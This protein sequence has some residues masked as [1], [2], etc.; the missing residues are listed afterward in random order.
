MTIHRLLFAC[1]A[2]VVAATA[3]AQ[4]PFAA[5]GADAAAIQTQVDAFRTALGGLNANT[6]GSVG[7]GRREINW[8]SAN[9]ALAAPGFLPNDF[10]NFLSP[11]GVVFSLGTGGTGFQ[12]SADAVNATG[13]PAEFGGINAT[14]PTAFAPFS[15]ERI[16]TAL[17]TN[18][19]DVHFLIPGSSTPAASRGFGAV[20][21]DVDSA[22]SS[23]LEFFRGKESLGVFTVQDFAGDAGLSF[24]GVDFGESIVTRVRVTTGAAALLDDDVTQNGANADIVAVDDFIYGEPVPVAS[25]FAGLAG[26]LQALRDAVADAVTTNKVEKKLV[27]PLDQAIQKVEQAEAKATA[28]KN[29]AAK[30][31]LKAGIARLRAF[32][33]AFDGADA[34]AEMDAETYDALASCAAVLGR[35]FTELPPP[36][37]P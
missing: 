9:D 8:D 5:A 22:T 21:C 14:Y 25:S 37:A 1:T 19:Y 31:L 12:V 24:L 32:E 33:K 35:Q 27:K 6:P 30:G 4:T 2:L 36:A 29:K 26:N 15:A 28:G 11:R 3:D 18:V 34:V 23:S 7:S 10:F 13:Q 16:F 20:F 17:D